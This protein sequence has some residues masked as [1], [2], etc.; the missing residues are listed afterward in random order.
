MTLF[1]R[2]IGQRLLW[3]IILI[4]WL[5]TISTI[6]ANIYITREIALADFKSEQFQS[7]SRDLANTAVEV[8]EQHGLIALKKWYRDVYRD[9]GLKVVLLNAD[10]MKLGRKD[11]LDRHDSF[12]PNPRELKHHLLSLA[13]LQIVSANNK[14][15]TFSALPSPALRSKFNPDTLHFYRFLSSFIIIFIGSYCL[16]RS[17]AKPLRVL[18]QASNQLA[19]GDFSVRTAPTIGKRNDELGQL[20]K[21]FDQ[22]AIKIEALI[23]NQKQ[24]FRDISHEIRTPLT[25]QKLALELAKSSDEP[26]NYVAKIELQNELIEGMINS[27]LTLMKLE[28]STVS[29]KKVLD[30]NLLLTKVVSDADLN[31]RDKAI[32]IKTEFETLPTLYGSELLLNSAFENILLN[33]IRYS[34]KSGIIHITTQQSNSCLIVSISDEGPGIPAADIAHILEPFYRADQSRNQKTGGFGLGLAIAK[35]VFQ[36][37]AGEISLSNKQPHGLNVKVSFQL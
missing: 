6:F 2:I 35:R 14:H 12:F 13:D 33:A 1:K 19:D 9:K 4:F 36:Q 30:L 27:L 17:I 21:A 18:Q 15:Y 31:L 37:H 10:G 29:D 22:M 16:A 32:G 5:T 3:K 23:G 28:E 20:S 26:L 8:Y 7:T 34:P 11:N 24:L 25:R